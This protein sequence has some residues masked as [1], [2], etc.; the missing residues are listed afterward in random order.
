MKIESAVR[1]WSD[2]VLIVTEIIFHFHDEIII[3]NLRNEFRIKLTRVL[4][5]FV[6]PQKC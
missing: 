1:K 4:D 3:F 6:G 2:N 5:V